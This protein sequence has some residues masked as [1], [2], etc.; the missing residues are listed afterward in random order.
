[1][2]LHSISGTKYNGKQSERNNLINEFKEILNL[3]KVNLKYSKAWRDGELE[4]LKSERKKNI[5]NQENLGSLKF[6]L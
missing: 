4:W 5:S 6:G 3:F 1:M 2:D